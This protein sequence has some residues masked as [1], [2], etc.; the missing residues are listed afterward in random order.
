[1]L[2]EVGAGIGDEEEDVEV[3]IGPRAAS[4]AAAMLCDSFNL[5]S[6]RC[7]WHEQE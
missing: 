2:D 1:M 4:Q 3:E 5:L 7:Q 6:L